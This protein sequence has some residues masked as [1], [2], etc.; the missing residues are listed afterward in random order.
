[1][2]A[3]QRSLLW[4]TMLVCAFSSQFGVVCA[5]SLEKFSAEKV[6]RILGISRLAADN[7][8]QNLS[9][10]AAREALVA[11]RP[12]AQLRQ[13][14]EEVL[15]ADEWQI[16]TD[17]TIQQTLQTLFLAWQKQKFDPVAVWDTLLAVV[18]PPN[19]PNEVCVYASRLTDSGDFP[20]A[21]D[22]IGLL[23]IQ[24]TIALKKVDELRSHIENRMPHPEA[25]VDAWHLLLQLAV[26]ENN[27]PEV[28]SRLQAFTPEVAAFAPR[29]S[30]PAICTSLFQCSNKRPLRDAS[31][32]ALDRALN[33]IAESGGQLDEELSLRIAMLLFREHMRRDD[34]AAAVN[35]LHDLDSIAIARSGTANSQLLLDHHVTIAKLLLQFGLNDAAM[36]RLNEIVALESEA[37]VES[38]RVTSRLMSLVPL[39]SRLASEQ[40]LPILRYCYFGINRRTPLVPLLTLN[41]TTT[42][43][44]AFGSLLPKSVSERDVLKE[45]LPQ[46]NALAQQG[47]DAAKIRTLVVSSAQ[48][49]IDAAVESG[50]AEAL[51]SD[52]L[53]FKSQGVSSAEYLLSMLLLQTGSAAEKLAIVQGI[54]REVTNEDRGPTTDAARQPAFELLIA[55]RAFETPELR[56]DAIEILRGLEENVRAADPVVRESAAIALAFATASEVPAAASVQKRSAATPWIGT[57]RF[58]D[59][60]LVAAIRHG[61]PVHEC[62]LMHQPSPTSETLYFPWPLTGTFEFAVSSFHD[63]AHGGGVGFDGLMHD[64]LPERAVSVVLAISE[65]TSVRRSLQFSAA[66]EFARRTVRVSPE[67]VTFLVNGHPVYRESRGTTGS[68][69]LSLHTSDH[70][71]GV[72][73]FPTLTGSPEIPREVR[74]SDDP[75]L[76]GWRSEVFGEL[77]REPAILSNNS[78]ALPD[79][80]LA[81]NRPLDW[82]WKDGMILGSMDSEVGG[83]QSLLQYD[84]PLLSGESIAW[85]FA[86]SPTDTTCS[87]AIGSLAF[88]IRPDGVSLHWIITERDVADL[89]PD[90]N[91]VTVL[92]DQRGAG[93]LQLTEGWNQ[94]ALS[95]RD[96]LLTLSVNN[97][98]IYAHK[99]RPE[100]S[101]QFGLF[102]FRNQSKAA[103][104]NMVLKGDWPMSFTDD[105]RQQMFDI[106]T[107][108][109]TPVEQHSVARMFGQK[110]FSA[111][112]PEIMTHAAAL[113]PKDR[114]EYL[115]D[116]ILPGASHSDWR[117]DTITAPSTS[118]SV[119][120]GT[121]LNEVARN[122]AAQSPP[123]QQIRQSS[124]DLIGPG[125]QLVNVAKEVGL[126]ADLKA[127]VDG[128]P[129]D[130]ESIDKQCLQLLIAIAEARADAASTL[131]ESLLTGGPDANSVS[132]QH[133][134]MLLLACQ[135]SLAVPELR[136]DVSLLLQRIT[137]PVWSDGSLRQT[138]LVHYADCLR[139]RAELSRLSAID[140]SAS[141][142]GQPFRIVRADQSEAGLP[143]P[144][145]HMGDEGS[146]Q[147]VSGFEDDMV[148]YA[149]P[150]EG[151]FVFECELT[152]VRG[153]HLMMGYGGCY[154]IPGNSEHDARRLPLG[155]DS[156]AIGKVFAVPDPDAL[157]RYRLSIERGQVSITINDQLIIKDT[158]PVSSP[159]WL[160]VR[161]TRTPGPVISNMRLSGN[162]TIPA[163]VTLDTGP[164]LQGWGR[165]FFGG[166]EPF[167]PGSR[168][169]SDWR[170]DESALIGPLRE[171]LDATKSESL[172]QY[173]RPMLEDGAISY[174]FYYE[175]GRQ[176]VHPALDQLTFL[177][178]AER[179]VLL[180]RISNGLWDRTWPDPASAEAEPEFQTVQSLPLQPNDWNAMQVTLEKNTLT[181]TLND[182]VIYRRPL[183]ASHRRSFGLFHFKDE[184]QA[185]VR[186][187]TWTGNW[188]RQLPAAVLS[189]E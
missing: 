161:A 96:D 6:Q 149:M 137:L 180:H 176:M 178:D 131:L 136:S 145:W 89:L 162:P 170:S 74:M 116:W 114:Y 138:S 153:E 97:V 85:E 177:L 182:V 4:M 99:L 27:I 156:I 84:R 55:M 36:D 83:K 11:G 87:P 70:K 142:L 67:E 103:V 57:Q 135:E 31:L 24:Q 117:L 90:D 78:D 28:R 91:E 93:K 68:P 61:W 143:Q 25:T 125:L 181:L 35:S 75:K 79:S 7:G 165:P 22:S 159:P 51:K 26:A 118:P 183:D 109:L 21:S 189:A 150:M 152:P 29:T 101:R 148:C 69:W 64:L 167:L 63:V 111:T 42:L 106:A 15:T 122:A 184:T 76:R 175:P 45:S 107:A 95:L 151:D 108:S 59:D 146:L 56:A 73:R 104:R 86:D 39:M 2:A 58:P 47:S 139:V 186:D 72:W 98:E 163:A 154:E 71:R 179:G 171:S 155:R 20:T 34:H 102:H 157:W 168:A 52:L 13:T 169:A 147:C 105:P 185:R 82:Q 187:L 172:L 62:V 77:R 16:K 133:A 19:S 112:L 12:A 17:A 38:T 53:N 60:E 37:A 124:G 123:G 115:V 132:E 121:E 14:A 130:V 81:T 43:P 113:S 188:P 80:P 9:L 66:G 134:S 23:L 18:L 1:M 129:S 100:D 54:L 33:R 46:Q 50:Q 49:L 174:S 119:S 160:C 48:M 3:S 10:R 30:L 141:P 127:R 94:A 110:P 128:I 44:D 140:A 40:R 5:Q 92:A 164:A 88:L 173:A 144:V 126:L 158:L 166:G 8:I 65:Q 41:T 32:P 120:T